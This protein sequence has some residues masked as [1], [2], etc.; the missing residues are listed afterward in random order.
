[1][2]GGV[3]ENPDQPGKDQ[4]A[5]Q[6]EQLDADLMAFAFR[7]ADQRHAPDPQAQFNEGQPYQQMGQGI[8][9]VFQAFR[10][11]CVTLCPALRL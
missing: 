11:Q 4:R 10:I 6:A 3:A 5:D 8:E 9:E 2:H 1:M 7:E